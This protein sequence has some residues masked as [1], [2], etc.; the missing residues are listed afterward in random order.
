MRIIARSYVFIV[1]AFLMTSPAI[2]E[3]PSE[4][5]QG[6]TIRL[7]VG[8][9]PGGGYDTYA[10]ILA[11]HLEKRTGATVIVEN[12]PGGSHTIAMNHVFTVAK[13]EGLTIMLAPGESAVLGSLL[14]EPGY[15]FDIS[16]F[17]V[18]G[19]LNTAPRILIVN[20]N[21]PYKTLDDVRRA[22]KPIM[23]GYTG[24][25]DGGSDTGAVFCHALKLPCKPVIGYK[26]SQEFTLAAIRGEL[27]GTILT[28]DSVVRYSKS[29]PL[30]PVVVTGRERSLLAPDVPTVFEATE[31]DEEARWWLDFRE[32]LRKLGRIL[33]T[34][35]GTPADRV[36]F[37]S[38]A[39]RQIT[40]DPAAVKDFERGGLPLR[41]A[42]PAEIKSIIDSF[43]GGALTPEKI[44]E[45]Q[46]VI[47]K[48]YY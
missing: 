17:E 3:S 38:T 14:G 23:L 39:V 2:A 36:N 1:A 33:I 46:F 21:S 24:I 18:L 45:I 6:K 41:Y 31:V 32:D 34:T 5:Y 22:Q 29:G 30:R 9:N 27:D 44:K 19:R 25:S 10:R 26:S 4:F 37:L 28:E 11:P 48:K 15:R 13:P 12:R 20:P 43:L 40:D 7:V 8:S 16:K 35:P 47:T 42:A